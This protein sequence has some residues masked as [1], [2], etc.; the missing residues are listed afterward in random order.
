MFQLKPREFSNLRLQIATARKGHGGRRSSPYAFTEHGA[1]MAATV[2]NSP[3]AVCMSVYVVRAFVRLRE[4]LSANKELIERIEG[5]QKHV[6][7]HDG[8][9]QEIVTVLKRLMN[10]TPSRSPKIGFRIPKA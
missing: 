3:Q 8:A 5:L 10:P 9:I 6:G 4:A 2:L 1:I 7:T